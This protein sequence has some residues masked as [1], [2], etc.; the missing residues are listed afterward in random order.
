MWPAI[1]AGVGTAAQLLGGAQARRDQRRAAR[2]NAAELARQA[3]L[4]R[5]AAKREAKNFRRESEIV[6]ADKVSSFAKAGVDLS[7]SVLQVLAQT[8]QQ[9]AE[10][11]RMIEQNGLQRSGV[12]AAQAAQQRSLARSIG[13]SGPLESVGTLLTGIGQIA[14]MGRDNNA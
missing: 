3:R 6:F 8:Q 7:G 5:E 4:E 1:I 2:Q 11:A 10:D 9:A 14:M 13:R 12:T